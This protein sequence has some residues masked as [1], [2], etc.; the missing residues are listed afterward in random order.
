MNL[1]PLSFL[2]SAEYVK[3]INTRG[4]VKKE[5]VGSWIVGVGDLDQCLHLWKYPG[6]Y[7]SVD[8]SAK[9]LRSDPVRILIFY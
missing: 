7:Q 4:D 2:A 9:T 8:E 1:L 3:A 5:L 6:G